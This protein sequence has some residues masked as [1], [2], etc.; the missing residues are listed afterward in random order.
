MVEITEL[1]ANNDLFTNPVLLLGLGFITGLL[2]SLEAD[3]IAAVATLKSKNIRRA[4]L[5]GMFWGLGHT[6]TLVFV[7]FLV[8]IFALSIP[9][10]LTNIVEYGVGIMLIVLGVLAIRKHTSLFN[11]FRK[12]HEHPH[13]HGNVIHIH[14]HTH[15]SEHTH[16]HRSI[17]IGM[18]H[19]FAGSGAIMLLILTT[20]DS[21]EVGLLYITIF[22]IGSIIG[23]VAIS[24]VIGAS[25]AAISNKTYLTKYMSIGIA[26]ISITVGTLI[27]YEM[28]PEIF[29]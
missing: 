26:I 9:Q 14:P 2:H 6:I 18:I 13:T 5:I 1:F 15:N 12:E 16:E 22:G 23:M 20:I 3:H 8:L 28:G 19:G 11:F 29:Y 10:I 21:I 17:I 25:F 7:G 27:M 24:T 4:P